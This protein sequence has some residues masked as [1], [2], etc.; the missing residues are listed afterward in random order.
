M[1]KQLKEISGK[2]LY[3]NGPCDDEFKKYLDRY[4]FYEPVR[5]FEVFIEFA[6]GIIGA[7]NFLLTYGFIEKVVFK[8]KLNDRVEILCENTHSAAIMGDI[9]VVVGLPLDENG[10]YKVRP[11][12]DDDKWWWFTEQDI[13][14][15]EEVFYK[16]GDV[17]LIFKYNKTKSLSMLA[18]IGPKLMQLIVI[19]DDNIWNLGNR[20][21]DVAIKV[22]NPN[23]ITEKEFAKICPTRNFK[24]VSVEIKE[25]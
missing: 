10:I 2:V 20:W 17:F 19:H 11:E 5:D 8:F 7:I 22:K 9:G 13:K 15:A 18:Q 23:K 14:I 6:R 24:R 16:R 25:V 21:D 12:F 3:E 1:Y 4:G